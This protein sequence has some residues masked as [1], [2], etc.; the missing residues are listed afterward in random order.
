MRAIGR[1]V[2]VMV[3]AALITGGVHAAVDQPAPFDQALENGDYAGAAKEIEKLASRRPSDHVANKWLDP[4]YGRFYAA[5][6]QGAVAEPY[7]ARAIAASKNTEERD[8]LVFEL[9]RAREVDGY[10]SKAEVDYR[11]LATEALEPSVRRDATLSVARLQLG[12]DPQAAVALLTPLIADATP[13]SGHWEAHLLLSR[14]YAI[15]TRAAEARS[16]L[17]AAWQEAPLAPQ[18]ADAIVITASDQAID[19]AASGD[20]AGEIGLISVGESTSRFAG[21][22]QLPVCG[23]ALRPEDSVT[24][25]I[26]ADPKQRPIYSAVRASR[27]G[28][29]QLFT[30]PLAVAQQR[31]EGSAIYV[32][33]HCRT[34]LDPNVR[35]VGGAMRDLSTFIAEKGSYPPLKP[36]DTSADDPLTQLKTLLQTAQS[37]AGV[38][39][40]SL[41]PTL[42]QL[43]LMQG[44]QSRFGNTA[45]LVEAKGYADRA[46]SI[47]SKAGAPEEVLQQVRLQ[48]TVGL[49]QNGNI[50]DVAGPA[51]IQA[52]NAILART[53]TTSL[54]A[55]SAFSSLSKWQLKPAQ[56]LGLA[57]TLITFLDSRRVAQADTVRQVA[58]LRRAA[59]VRD[60]GTTVGMTERLVAHGLPADICGVAEKPPSIPPSAITLTSDDYP[61]DLLRRD[62]SGLTSIELS[63]SAT[64]KI[65]GARI[66]A[67]QPSGLFDSIA[68]AKLAS[69]SLLPAQRNN[70]AAPCRGMVQNVRWQVPFHGDFSMPFMGYSSP[71]D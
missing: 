71:D 17:E 34:A 65:E 67:S 35:F 2:R 6:A 49:A 44:A 37:K 60:V 10:V 21:S 36:L 24:I 46:L 58:E 7:L 40:L 70:T 15:L 23:A 50:A 62:V 3:A 41:T 68:V 18:P 32:T 1:S 63:V 27:P 39:E 13:V 16:A 64:G 8:R 59:I 53:S 48:I 14:A 25:A 20:R 55:L 38:N 29:A 31:I 42:L 28:I 4:Y 9:A 69:I 26:T 43:A 56:Q 66:I 5:A 57:D 30:V 12:A 11:R 51:A 33:L 22:A 45:G 19:R 61:K 54:Q 52:M 47:L